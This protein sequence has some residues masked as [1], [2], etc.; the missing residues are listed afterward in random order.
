[1]SPGPR[2]GSSRTR[3]N[4]S[5]KTMWK[6]GQQAADEVRQQYP[7]LKDEEVDAYVKR[8]GEQLVDNIPTE[9]RQPAFRYTFQVVNLQGNQRLRPAGR[10][11]VPEPGHARRGPDR[12]R[13]HRRHGP[14]DQPRRA[15]A[16]HRAGH[17]GPEVPGWRDRGADPRRDCRGHAGSVISQGTQF[18]LGATSSST[19]ASTSA[20]RT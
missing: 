3:I 5:R 19:A 20:K 6:L 17:Q 9:L 11:D 1:M 16:R 12:R 4:T 8:L 15:A 18:G 10:P 7:L 14:R 2:P 13:S